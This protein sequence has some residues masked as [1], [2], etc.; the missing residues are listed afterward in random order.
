MNLDFQR[1]PICEEG[2]NIMLQSLAN[3]PT[4]KTL[5]LC[6]TGS[7]YARL[8]VS[9]RLISADIVRDVIPCADDSGK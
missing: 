3:H 9:Q 6:Y 7:F 4:L 1:I 2:M 5:N 8:L